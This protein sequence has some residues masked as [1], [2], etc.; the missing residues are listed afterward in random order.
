MEL[1][2]EF[3]SNLEASQFSMIVIVIVVVVELVVVV[4]AVAE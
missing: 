4:V 2:S 3:E 1:D